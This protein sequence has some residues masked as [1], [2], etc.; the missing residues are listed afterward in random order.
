MRI[1]RLWACALAGLLAASGCV[2]GPT[3]QDPIAQGGGG[4]EAVALTAGFTN[5]DGTPAAGIRVRLRPKQF[6]AD[7][8]G[9][10]PPGGGA[11]A[12]LA[13]TVR[14]AFTDAKGRVHLDSVPRGEYLLEANDSAGHA[15]LIPAMVTGDSDAFFL[16]EAELKSTGSVTG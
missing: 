7:T 2:D 6:L 15:L 5:A 3:G 1:D 10:P 9:V 16:P 11:E 8:L 12:G 14:D 13:G 4:S